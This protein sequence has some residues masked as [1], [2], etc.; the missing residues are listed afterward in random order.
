VA[1]FLGR[2]NK[3]KG[4]PELAEAFA[5][6]ARGGADS[7][8]LLL[9][10]PD[11][12]GMREL[13]DGK[14]GQLSQR[15]HYVDYTDRPESFMASADFFVMPSHREGFGSTVIEAAACGVPA[16][17]TRIYGLTD[18]V[19]DGVTGLLVPDHDR[20]S[21]VAAIIK[22]TQDQRLRLELGRNA[23]ERVRVDFRQDQL[24]AAV[25]GFYERILA[26]LKSA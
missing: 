1:L 24:V 26:S 21:L 8:H 16:I 6:A 11:E 12:T 14:V 5:L 2:L 19:V 3:D 4:I 10:G 20:A 18:A 22:L 25:A 23:L 15:V 7:L 9:V 13:V 17:A